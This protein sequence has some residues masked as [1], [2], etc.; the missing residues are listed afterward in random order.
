MQIAK[1]TTTSDIKYL[2]LNAPQIYREWWLHLYYESPHHIIIETALVLFIIWLLFI[3]KTIDPVRE[4]KNKSLTKKEEEWLIET[5]KPAP[6]VEPQTERNNMIAS[7]M[8]VCTH[9]FCILLLIHCR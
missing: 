4:S 8:I 9:Y 1:S 7:E 2:I 6:L 3:R 5:W